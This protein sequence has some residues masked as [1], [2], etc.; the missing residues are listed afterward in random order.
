MKKMIKNQF[1]SQCFFTVILLV[2]AFGN[3]AYSQSSG[4]LDITFGSSGTTFT[5]LSTT[6][7]NLFPRRGIMQSDGK[8]LALCDT[9]LNASN[10]F[11]DVVIRYNADGTI[12]SNFGSGGFLLMNWNTPSNG[13]GSAYALTTQII[14]NDEK[15]LLAGS[16]GGSGTLRVDRY[17]SNGTP[18][19]SFGPDG[20][21]IYNVGYALTMTIQPDGKILTM[22]DVGTMVRINS[23]GTLDNSFGSGGVV[24]ISGFRG[25]GLAVQSTGRI[26]IGGI[27]T[28]KGK[29]V[30]SVLRF[31]TNGTPDDKG[32]TDSTP[33]DVFGSNGTVIIEFI[34]GGSWSADSRNDWIKL[35]SAGKILVTGEAL[36]KNSTNGLFGVARLT[37]NGQFDT[38]FDVDG[39]ATVDLSPLSDSPRSIALQSDGKILLTG[40]V[41][42]SVNRNLGIARFNAN[43]SLDTG[44]ATNGLVIRDFSPSPEWSYAGRIQFDPLCSCEKLVVIG[45]AELNVIDYA[46][47]ARYLLQ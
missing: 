31:N 42:S 25:Y 26:L 47:A 21:R 1:I 43:G 3:Q 29:N 45:A 23:D 12:D 33:N 5:N 27:T 11:T 28:A 6:D 32:R 40:L 13:Y 10:G 35:D 46:V 14:N 17:N 2:F 22:G 15:I 24:Q 19:L 34:T 20:R 39:K 4:T 41:N 9:H 7:N 30:L 36:P 38:T 8:A 16:Y 44:F 37:A 18:D